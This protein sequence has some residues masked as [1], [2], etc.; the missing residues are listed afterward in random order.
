ML[1]RNAQD[2]DTR[3]DKKHKGGVHDRHWGSAPRCSRKSHN[4]RR[5]CLATKRM[6]GGEDGKGE[7]NP[8]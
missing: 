5:L 7:G 8:K 3:E 2:R 1:T 4:R 6:R